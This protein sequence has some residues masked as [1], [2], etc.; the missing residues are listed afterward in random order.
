M[1]RISI[2]L[3]S[4][5]FCLMACKKEEKPLSGTVIDLNLQIK[6]VNTNN[7]D[8]LKSQTPNY[9]DVADLDVFV[10][11]GNERK[12]VYYNHLYAP[13]LI[14]VNKSESNPSAPYDMTLC[15]DLAYVQNNKITMIIRYKDGTED[16]F[17]TLINEEQKA[18]GNYITEKMWHNN[19]LFWDRRVPGS[20][21]AHITLIK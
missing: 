20:M 9:I 14:W 3:F 13:K 6:Y 17:T 21:G 18:F 7:E 19:E 11:Q 2:L 12:R 16:T 5:S 1:K 8:L 4:L 15:F 10:M